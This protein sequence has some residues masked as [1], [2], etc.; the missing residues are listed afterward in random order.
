MKLLSYFRDSTAHVP[1]LL[2]KTRSQVP[3]PTEPED[4]A[5]LELQRQTPSKVSVAQEAPVQET[6]PIFPSPT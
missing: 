4:Q 6:Y 3:L 1:S 5:Q 2:R